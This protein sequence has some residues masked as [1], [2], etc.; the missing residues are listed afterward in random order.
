MHM[1]YAAN[2]NLRCEH[3]RS[4]FGLK[5]REWCRQ[6]YTTEILLTGYN[7]RTLTKTLID[8]I[9]FWLLMYVNSKCEYHFYMN[10][11]KGLTGYFYFKDPKEA[12]HFK[13]KWVGN[14][15]HYQS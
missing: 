11:F 7:D 6:H 2:D 9:N 10:N 13:L 1:E 14:G 3:E 8:Q 5:R 4:S 15:A 12:M